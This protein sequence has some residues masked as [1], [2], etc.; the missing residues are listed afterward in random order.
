MKTTNMNYSRVNKK[1]HS[2]QLITKNILQKL[3]LKLSI[4]KNKIKNKKCFDKER[5]FSK[6]FGSIEKSI[7]YEEE[8]I[9]PLYTICD[10]DDEE[11][12]GFSDNEEYLGFSDDDEYL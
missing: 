11:Y 10:E 5:E 1:K 4:L 9:K 2:I 7:S 8:L 3:L 6:E 12:L